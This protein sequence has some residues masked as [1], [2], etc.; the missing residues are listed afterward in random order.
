[1]PGNA[2]KGLPILSASLRL[3]HQFLIFD[4]QLDFS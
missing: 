1:M 2:V 4:F 3:H